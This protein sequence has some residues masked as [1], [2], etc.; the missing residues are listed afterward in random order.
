MFKGGF[1]IL[2]MKQVALTA[3]AVNYTSIETGIFNKIKNCDLPVIVVNLKVG[4]TVLRPSVV[5]FQATSST[6][7][8]GLVSVEGTTITNLLVKSD[9]KAKVTQTELDIKST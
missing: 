9:D 1:Q 4:S 3:N 5:N 7:Y 2:D 6:V 8:E